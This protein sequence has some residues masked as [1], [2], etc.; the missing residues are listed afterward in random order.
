MQSLEENIRLLLDMCQKK[1]QDLDNLSYRKKRQQ[2]H[3]LAF[4]C[5]METSYSTVLGLI[6][7]QG[8]EEEMQ[9]FIGQLV[10]ESSE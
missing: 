3:A 6:N 5:G 1:R 4:Y 2:W 10:G 7:R 9:K 8:N